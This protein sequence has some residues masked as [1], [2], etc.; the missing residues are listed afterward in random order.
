MLRYN[1]RLTLARKRA[2]FADAEF[3]AEG[4]GEAVVGREPGGED[5]VLGYLCRDVAEGLDDASADHEV[6]VADCGS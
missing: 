1:I 4:G 6:V 5:L 3:E 2:Y